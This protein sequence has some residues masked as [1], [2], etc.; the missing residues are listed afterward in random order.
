MWVPSAQGIHLSMFKN[1]VKNDR[2]IFEIPALLCFQCWGNPE[3]N[4]FNIGNQFGFAFINYKI[5]PVDP[6]PVFLVLTYIPCLGLGPIYDCIFW[7]RK[8]DLGT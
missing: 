6:Y 7:M 5:L 4:K 3:Q 1:W 8:E 2:K